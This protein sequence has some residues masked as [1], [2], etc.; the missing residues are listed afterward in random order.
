MTPE[1]EKL[2]FVLGSFFMTPEERFLDDLSSELSLSGEKVGSV[3]WDKVNALRKRLYLSGFLGV[4]QSGM[5]G[6]AGLIS[7]DDF[8]NKK[9]FIILLVQ[10]FLLIF[11]FFDFLLI[12]NKEKVFIYYWYLK[13]Y[14]ILFGKVFFFFFHRLSVQ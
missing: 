14:L 9:R 11:F 2:P 3:H 8:L 5:L 6:K 12:Y 13:K 7:E 4:R 10:L 1:E